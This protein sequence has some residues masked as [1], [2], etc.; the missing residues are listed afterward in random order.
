MKNHK[1]KYYVITILFVL[2][3]ISCNSN[4]TRNRIE[5][6]E[7]FLGKEKSNALNEKVKC[8]EI[9]IKDNFD[10]LSFEKGVEKYL[11]IIG[12]NEYLSY[13]WD[14]KN[15]DKKRI[16]ELFKK[17]GLDKE[18]WIKP[19]TV[20]KDKHGITKK[21]Y[22][23]ENDTL[24]ITGEM[25]PITRGKPKSIDEIIEEEKEFYTFNYNSKFIKALD[26]IKDNDSLIIHYL[27]AKIG[28]GGDLDAKFIANEL[29]YDKPEYSDYF[30]KRIIVI[31][32][33]NTN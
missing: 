27:D 18:L 11:K 3:L 14:F 24:T 31:E 21:Y 5:K 17:S 23:D 22:I 29:L 19:D 4:S 8:F 32:L 2:I 28:S 16:T 20:Y 7:T 33:F 10:S 26:L 25:L 9:F 13:E 1:I 6:F 15:I 30:T 12:K